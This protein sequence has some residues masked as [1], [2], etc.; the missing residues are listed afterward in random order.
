MNT[1]MV[2]YYKERANEYEKI[3]A[4]PE[5]QHDLLLATQILQEAFRDKEVLE[6][7]CGTGYWTKI[8]SKT[9]DSIL[10]TDINDAVINLAKSKAYFASK[11]KFQLV[12]I[13]NLAGTTK[14]ESLFGGFIWSHIK[15]QELVRFID[16]INYQVK[17]GRSL[18]FMDNNFV[19]GSNLPLTD[20]DNFGNTYQTRQLE[21]GTM[22]KVVKNFPTEDFIK[23]LLTNKAKNIEF[24]KLEY[25]W[26][27]KYKT[28]QSDSFLKQP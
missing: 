4:R 28:I 2:S 20:I 13:F 26:I 21:N 7:A 10:A 16:T 3:Y 1:D 15:L 8:I 19:E 23:Q 5:R 11:I 24:I 27:L 14:H 18:V 17:P 12:D 25:Y 22:Y 6:I 9:A